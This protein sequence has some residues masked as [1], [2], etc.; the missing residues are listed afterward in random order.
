MNSRRLLRHVA[1]LAVLATF[2][3]ASYAAGDVSSST[4]PADTQ[5]AQASTPAPPPAAAPAPAPAPAAAPAPLS[6]F[7]LTVRCNG[8]RRRPSTPAHWASSPST[9][10]LPA[11][12]SS[13]TTPS[14]RRR[15]GASHSDQRSDLH[16]EGG[17]EASVLRPG[18]RLR[19]ADARVCRLLTPKIP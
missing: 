12:R 1:V 4:A 15:R 17:R 6:T 13:R 9:A 19:L 2:T 5:E 3:A 16:S 11:S 8:C 10:S 18:G 14:L 7:V